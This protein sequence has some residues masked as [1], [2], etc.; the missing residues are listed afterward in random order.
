MLS[1]TELA[2]AK[3]CRTLDGKHDADT[4]DASHGPVGATP[5]TAI[6][7][8]P[9]DEDMMALTPLVLP[10][11]VMVAE[12]DANGLHGQPRLH[13]QAMEARS[14]NRLGQSAS[15]DPQVC[16]FLRSEEDGTD[17]DSS[18]GCDDSSSSTSSGT[19]WV[20]WPPSA[21]EVRSQQEWVSLDH[22]RAKLLLLFLGGRDWDGFGWHDDE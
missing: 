1:D 6:P 2:M 9:S 19:S 4:T 11:S 20:T 16:A 12:E 17:S 7:D 14:A 13:P 8:G 10:A 5:E 15:A 21:F 18:S 22:P 3:C